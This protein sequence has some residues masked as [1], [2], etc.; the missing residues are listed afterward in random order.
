MLI[1]DTD[2]HRY[3]QPQITK[4]IKGASAA[5]DGRLKYVS[6]KENQTPFRHNQHVFI[7]KKDFGK[8][9]H[10]SKKYGYGCL[11]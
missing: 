4:S 2:I 10:P 1:R 11:D 3:P 6:C 5:K 7:C 8:C 9:D